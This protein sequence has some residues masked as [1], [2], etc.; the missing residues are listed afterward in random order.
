LSRVIA[1]GDSGSWVV[2]GGLLCGMIVAGRDSLPWAYMICIE[3]IFSDIKASIGSDA[4]VGLPSGFQPQ[5]QPLLEERPPDRNDNIIAPLAPE[6]HLAQ[7]NEK[8][9]GG[10]APHIPSDAEIYL[11]GYR[12]WILIFTL[13][14]SMF[15]VS[16]YPH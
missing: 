16:D 8:V 5:T 6:P 14:L 9:I 2:R 7:D 15:L 1:Y 3:E 4:W 10:Q 11:R 12:L 13:M